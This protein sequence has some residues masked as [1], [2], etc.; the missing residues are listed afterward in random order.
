M[1]SLIVQGRLGNQMF[2]YSF[3]R[4]LQEK[5]FDREIN[6]DF[7]SVYKT[8]KPNEGWEN[9]LKYFNVKTFKETTNYGLSFS[10]KVSN[11]II[12]HLEK[13]KHSTRMEEHIADLKYIDFLNKQGILKLTMGYY[14]FKK[15]NK[16]NY[17]AMGYFESDKYFNFIRNQLLEEF[18]SK[19]DKLLK[20]KKL[21]NIIENNNSVCISIRRRG[22]C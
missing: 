18:T 4:G 13:N 1:I 17:L 7:S 14:D 20:N 9:S 5:G 2:Q 12:N 8:N 3:L 10:Q 22:F 16:E 15:V 6:M 19:Y 21:Y 11:K